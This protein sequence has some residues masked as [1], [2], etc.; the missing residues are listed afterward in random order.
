MTCGGEVTFLFEGHHA[1]GWN[2]VVFGAG[3]VGQALTR[4]LLPLP[5]RVAVID[6]RAEWVGASSRGEQCGTAPPR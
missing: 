3:H 4:A 1:V 6:H 5:C 2:I